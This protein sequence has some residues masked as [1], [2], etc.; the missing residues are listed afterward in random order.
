MEATGSLV[1][2][3]ER[4]R[5]TEQTVM[6]TLAE[7]RQ[8]LAQLKQE[9][10]DRAMQ[11]EERLKKSKTR[12]R[13]SQDIVQVG[14]MQRCSEA[15]KRYDKNGSGYI[16]VLELKGLLEELHGREVD[17]R[18]FTKIMRDHDANRD[19]RMD[20]SE[21][22]VFYSYSDA[23]KKEYFETQMAKS[24]RSEYQGDANVKQSVRIDGIPMKALKQY[25]E[26]EIDETS[27]CIQFIWAAAKFFFFALS[28]QLHFRFDQ[29][30]AI[31]QAIS[32]DVEENANFAFSGVVP[33]ENGRM[34]HSSFHDVNSIADFWS[35]FQM[36][37]VP[38]FWPQDW[39]VSEV[40]ANML[41]RCSG[42]KDALEG[43]GWLASHLNGTE[44]NGAFSG[45]CPERSN[46]LQWQQ[47][48]QNFFGGQKK[49]DGHYLFF[50]QHRGRCPDSPRA[51]SP[52]GL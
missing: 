13:I 5:V 22:M 29:V 49:V 25:L 30:Y 27:S 12:V 11:E 39:D 7:V 36:G 37:L 20:F 24:L 6:E 47:A 33:S 42:Q 9:D 3:Y 19:G 43:F 45:P 14:E 8:T 10:E 35:W 32:W 34:G 38:V 48:V 46:E 52:R 41:A 44:N 50:F 51:R 28:V 31:E 2:C 16:G 26:K 17:D 21:F 15:F 23:Q 4:V 40:R 18:E 1:R